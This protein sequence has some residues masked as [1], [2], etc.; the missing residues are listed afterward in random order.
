MVRRRV[1]TVSNHEAPLLQLGLHPS[2]RG[3]TAAAQDE[4]MEKE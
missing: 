2:R 3:L 1:G 4:E